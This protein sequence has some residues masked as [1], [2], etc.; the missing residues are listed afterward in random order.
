MM[1]REIAVNLETGHAVVLVHAEWEEI[2]NYRSFELLASDRKTSQALWQ[3]RSSLL[4]EVVPG[5]YDCEIVANLEIGWAVVLDHAACDV[6]AGYCL[7][8][9]LASD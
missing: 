1:S 3:V 2:A 9:L 5:L 8:G 6:A 4:V 7:F